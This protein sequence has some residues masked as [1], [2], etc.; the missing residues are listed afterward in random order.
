MMNPISM[1][2]RKLIPIESK[3]A[4]CLD[5]KLQFFGPSGV[6]TAI[7][8]KGASFHGILHKM[9]A[10]QMPILDAIEMSYKRTPATAKFY[11]K[12][13]QQCT[14]YVM[15]DEKMKEIFG[16]VKQEDKPPAERY[17]EIMI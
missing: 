11:D 5:Y 10:D 13:T 16:G 8:E 6:A 9:P 4:E 3:A 2:A 1:S 7:P 17:V 14:V 15:D 12:T